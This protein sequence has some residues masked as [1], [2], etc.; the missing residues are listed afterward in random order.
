M[1]TARDIA[2]VLSA[3]V[4]TACWPVAFLFIRTIHKAWQ[5]DPLPPRFWVALGVCISFIGS[6][7]NR[8][9]AVLRNLGVIERGSWQS[10][11]LFPLTYLPIIAGIMILLRVVMVGRFGWHA[12]LVLVSLLLVLA[13][14]L[15]LWLP[16]IFVRP[17]AL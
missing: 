10:L 16:T 3:F 11:Y 2:S 13:M 15:G 9:F 12:Y 4:A 17:G 5:E 14:V 6:G 7:L 8:D 1:V